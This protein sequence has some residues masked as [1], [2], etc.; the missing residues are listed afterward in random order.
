MTLPT[1]W[2]GPRYFAAQLAPEP[3]RTNWTA[4]VAQPG[5]VPPRPLNFGD[6]LGGA[7]RAVRFAPMTMFGLTL[8]VLMIAQLLGIGAGYVLGR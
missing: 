2:D 3:V 6:I 8:V 1:G 7:F 5:V 4:P